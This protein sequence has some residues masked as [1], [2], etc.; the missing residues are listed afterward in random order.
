MIGTANIFPRTSNI[1]LTINS[2]TC[3]WLNENQGSFA[4]FGAKFWNSICDELR[5]LLK[6]A[7]KT[8]I[9]DM[10]LSLLE[11]EDDYD[12]VSIPLQKIANYKV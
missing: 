11:A 9:S 10:L 2:L 6:T 12:Q 5:Q 8:H 3:L 7:F 4:R 1:S